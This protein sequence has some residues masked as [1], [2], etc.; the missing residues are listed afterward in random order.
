MQNDCNAVI[1]ITFLPLGSD[2]Y[3]PTGF[4]SANDLVQVGKKHTVNQ[5]PGM[6]SA[7]NYHHIMTDIQ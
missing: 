7:D 3:E 5:H 4:N 2:W 6:Y 1:Y